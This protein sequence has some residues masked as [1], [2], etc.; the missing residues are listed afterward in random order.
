VSR[1]KP[2]RLKLSP[3]R[4]P[5]GPGQRHPALRRLATRKPGQSSRR[6]RL[7]TCFSHPKG[8]GTVTSGSTPPFRRRYP[9]KGQARDGDVSSSSQESGMAIRISRHVFCF[10]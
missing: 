3:G 10:T 2:E 4:K 9:R 1:P 8:A 6:A 5:T 7:E